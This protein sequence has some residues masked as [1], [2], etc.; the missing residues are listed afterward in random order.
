MGFGAGLDGCGVQKNFFHHRQLVTTRST[1]CT[2]PNAS[3]YLR[4]LVKP[5][6]SPQLVGRITSPFPHGLCPVFWATYHVRGWSAN[7][8]RGSFLTSS[9][10]RILYVLLWLIDVFLLWLLCSC[11]QPMSVTISS[12]FSPWIRPLLHFRASETCLTLAVF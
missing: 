11:R 3:E 2:I 9:L 10:T 4:M 12:R 8:G 5:K 1:D 7:P 6:R